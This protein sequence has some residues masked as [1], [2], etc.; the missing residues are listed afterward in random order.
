MK[1]PHRPGL[2]LAL[3]F[4]NQKQ[5]VQWCISQVIIS[6]G[7]SLLRT[8]PP[9]TEAECRGATVLFSNP[10]VSICFPVSFVL[11]HKEPLTFQTILTTRAKRFEKKP[12]FSWKAPALARTGAGTSALSPARLDHKGLHHLRL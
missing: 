7:S 11:G 9:I 2:K 4:L 8:P 10:S 5:R 1:L 3:G 6:S 12:D